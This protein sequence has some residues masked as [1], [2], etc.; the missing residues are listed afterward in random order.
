[1]KEDCISLALHPSGFHIVLGL[2]DRVAMM[3]IL[4]DDLEEYKPIPIKGC[5]EIQF[6]NGGQYFACTHQN[7][8][9]VYK[10][11]TGETQN[12]FYFKGHGHHVK[13]I[14]WLEDDTGFVTCGNDSVI[15]LW[16][17]YPDKLGGDDTIETSR[18]GLPIWKFEQKNYTFECVTVYHPEPSE[19]DKA[20]EPCVFATCTDKSVRKIKTVT[21]KKDA[22]YTS[23]AKEVGR[24]YEEGTKYNQVVMS[25]QGKFLAVGGSEAEKPAAIQLFRPNFDKAVEVQAH[26]KQINRLKLNF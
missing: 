6:S 9:Q 8:V 7:V 5:K 1:M 26:S 24:Y 4:N 19:T 14:S 20:A 21:E 25:S 2:A 3:N 22:V 18:A 11:Y 10:F 15:F 23:K 12:D 17:L 16:K 13:S